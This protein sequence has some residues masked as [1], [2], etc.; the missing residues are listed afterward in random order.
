[1]IWG[2]ST[3]DLM[4]PR[5]SREKKAETKKEDGGRGP[6]ESDQNWGVMYLAVS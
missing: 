1:M 2:K 5:R 3:D 4:T 6:P